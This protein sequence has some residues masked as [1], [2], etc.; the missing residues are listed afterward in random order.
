MRR[1]L[2]A[3]VFL[4]AGATLYLLS[5]VGERHDILRQVVHHNDAWA[6]S[7]TVQEVLRLESNVAVGLLNDQE[8]NDAE[9]VL[10]LDIVF[11]RL[12]SLYEGTLNTFLK[13]VPAR[14]ETIQEL[15]TIL[16]ELDQNLNSNNRVETIA[17]LT[18]LNSIISDIT[19]FSSQ[20]VQQS[21]ASVDENLNDLDSLHEV[22]GYVVAFFIL[23]WCILL[24][25][26]LRQNYL[27]DNAQ[28]R[29]EDL[30]ETLIS[31][32]LELS[33]KNQL[34]E[35][36]AHHD[37]LT[38][39][40]NRTPLWSMLEES[41]SNVAT[42]PDKIALLL[43]DLDDFKCVNDTFGH[44]TGDSL[45]CQVSDRLR[46][47]THSPLMFSRLGG[48]E[49]ACVL[50]H[51]SLD[52]AVW[53]AR[54][55]VSAISAPYLIA[56]RQIKIGCSIGVA[57]VPAGSNDMTAQTMFKFADIALYRAKASDLDRVCLFEY[58]MA[59]E[60]DDRK[61][62]ETD[63]ILAIQAGKI[64]VNYQ[65]QIDLQSMEIR[66]ME[67]LARWTHSVRGSIPP[68]DFIAIAEEIGVV[69]DL[70]LLVLTKACIEACTWKQPTKL[71]VNVSPIQL[72][73]PDFIISVKHVL[74]KTGLDPRRLELE[75]TESALLEDQNDL[76]CVLSQ[77]RSFGISVAIDDFGKGHSSL[78]RLRS[79]PFDTIKLDKS[80]V[81]GI[82]KDKE[83]QDFLKMVSDLGGL[84]RKE[85]I[86][87][88]IETEEEH[89]IVRQLHCDVAQGFLFGR[90]V[91][92][93]QLGHLRSIALQFG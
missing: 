55:L 80:F 91:A 18:E 36:A 30:N 56:G 61:Q 2:Y 33:N 12:A 69:Q 81:R 11:S 28:R 49:F 51:R 67:A 77:L 63:L 9:T 24:A 47:M 27:L 79:L 37:P 64:D 73:D 54:D 20:A 70:G 40:P 23:C 5:S 19:R 66:G 38:D 53:Y 15:Q 35:Y 13:E 88:G 89:N 7:Q 43:I 59:Q 46:N 29:T 1:I 72:Q 32:G 41:L 84:L 44:D 85:V 87:E 78:A 31:T 68:S 4:F 65:T 62:F 34:L 71:A 10:R 75:I 90:P 92:N 26:L 57:T 45:L 52:E 22:F 14:E 86:I 60:F 17:T 76:A 42:E 58:Y 74:S 16:N 25:V 48:D 21:W 6:V 3:L 82:T 50:C 93:S 39:L 83:A 8:L